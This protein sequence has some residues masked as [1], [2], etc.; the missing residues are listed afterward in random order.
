MQNN[1]KALFDELKSKLTTHKI[2]KSEFE[3]VGVKISELEKAA[4]KLNMSDLKANLTAQQSFNQRF[5]DKI[6]PAGLET[7]IELR[8]LQDVLKNRTS[9]DVRPL[10]LKSI[11]EFPRPIPSDNARAIE[12]VQDCFDDIVILYTDYTGED[13]KI[14]NQ[15]QKER[16]PI[17]FGTL[18]YTD[19]KINGKIHSNKLVFIT[20]WED[21]YCDLT[22]DKLVEEFDI[23]AYKLEKEVSSSIDKDV[24]ID[25]SID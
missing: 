25:E 22:L 23:N 8:E 5:V 7:Y 2:S 18:T 17:A 1:I 13:R 24:V 3:E 15:V 12:R 6:I 14:D 20:D 16:D 10:L 21:M 11:K 9:A 4:K 19:D